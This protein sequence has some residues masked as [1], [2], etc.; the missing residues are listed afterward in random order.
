MPPKLLTPQILSKAKE[1]Y[2]KIKD[3]KIAKKLMA[4]IAFGEHKAEDV[5]KIFMISRRTLTK[6]VKC[7]S[8]RGVEG[9]K[10]TR[11][12]NYPRKLSEEEWLEVKSWILSRRSPENKEINWTLEKLQ[13]YIEE[14][15]SKRVSL[16]TIKKNLN[17]IGIVL[18]RARPIHYKADKDDQDDMPPF[19]VKL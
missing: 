2:D 18:R 15:F 6:W 12:G 13:I 19:F 14:R 11:G 1:E 7:F 16:P 5:A 17:R 10:E 3:G 4:I 8:E 9:L